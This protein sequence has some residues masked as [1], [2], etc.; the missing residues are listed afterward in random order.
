MSFIDALTDQELKLIKPFFESLPKEI[1]EWFKDGADEAANLIKDP[2]YSIQAKEKREERY[3][4]KEKA[5]ASQYV[6]AKDGIDAYQ[7]D[8]E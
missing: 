4:E 5:L 7:E 3:N 6:M 1:V 8:L 2:N